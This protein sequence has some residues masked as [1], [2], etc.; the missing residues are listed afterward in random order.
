MKSFEVRNTF[1]KYFE[2]QKHTH[3]SS[4]SLIPENDATILFANAGMNQFKNVFLGIE[5]R[6][7]SRAVSS[8]KCVRAGGKHN[9][10]E[11]VGITAR[12]HTFFEMLGNFSFGDY[13]KKDAIRF[14][15]DLLLK[16]Y[17]FPKDKLYVSVF[18][19][20]HEAAD[21]WHKQ[22]GVAKDRIFRF[23]EKDNFWRMGDTGPCGPCT[24]IFYDHGSDSGCGKPSCT[25]GCSCDRYVEIWNNVFMQF[26]EDEN[27]KQTPLPKPSV[28][29][30]AGL[31]RLTAALQGKTNN[32]DTDLFAPMIQT[33]AKLGKVEYGTNP[34]TTTALRVMADHARATAFLI[35]DGAL[36]SNEGRGYVL[37]RIMRR[38][39]RYGRS[40][41]KDQSLFPAVVGSVIEH[42]S[43]F[44]PELKQS[45]DRILNSTRDEE[46]R[47]IHTLDQGTEIM[48]QT[49]S[50]Q[51]NKVLDGA[52]VFK[53]YDTFGF[54]ADLTALMAKE[55]GF[56]IDEAGFE[57][58]MQK[59]RE[60]SKASWKGTAITEDRTHL[61]SLVQQATK[62]QKTTQFVGYESFSSKARVLLLSD[63]K[64]I[65][66]SLSKGSRGYLITD[67]TPFYAEGGGQIG[68]QGTVTGNEVFNCTKEHEIYI[69]HVNI[70]EKEIKTSDKVD[71]IVTT[72]RRKKT[73]ANHSATHLMHAA[74]RKILGSHIGQAGSLVNEEKLRFDFTH[75]QPVSKKELLEI[76]R[77]VNEEIAKGSEVDTKIT[78]PKKAAEEGAMALFGEKYGD[79]VRVIKMGD[80][81][82]ELC[83]GTHVSNTSNILAFKVTSEGGVSAGVRRIEAI[84]GPNAIQYLMNATAELSEAKQAI[85]TIEPIAK[86][87]EKSRE[88]IKILERQIKSLQSQKIDVDQFIKE[89]KILNF[90]GTEAKLVTAIIEMD[91]RQVLSEIADKLKNKVSSGVVIVIGKGE[92]THPI[93][94]TVSN[95]LTGK[96]KA[97]DVL[98]SL[99]ATMGGKGGGRP[100]FAQGAGNDFSKAKESIAGVVLQFQ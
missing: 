68:D 1:I 21:I 47:F 86:W 67:T 66:N 100:D 83:G 85:G 6:N 19:T 7:Y 18:E 60:T 45:S 3:V 41:S 82:M 36:P 81:S 28:D 30:G 70:T 9:D 69:H 25:V 50:K 22:E 2:G 38:G 13:F 16:K 27:G 77:L 49:L 39:I 97:G 42:M 54:P 56:E 79:E 84:T 90:G 24:E 55:K 64:Q 78:T 57:K 93:I 15:W 99:T 65:V 80:F 73:M 88:D 75:N 32:Y 31:E 26:Y 44:Y 52:F 94:V 23:G 8:Q 10:L 91:D 48:T 76:E 92:E 58:E 46:G 12:H 34:K 61:V 11:N 53:L 71:L 29:T 89:A 33:A 51:K 63:G 59:A 72:G 87:I 74:L 40:I 4:S 17:G 62:M 96:V 95:N 43:S 5:K 37:R 20:D 98:K 14:A 35:A